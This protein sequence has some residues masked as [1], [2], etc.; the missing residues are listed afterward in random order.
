MDVINLFLKYLKYEKHVSPYTLQAYE[1]DLDQLNTYLQQDHVDLEFTEVTH[2]TLR[3]W[4]V[5]LSTLGLKP[6]SIN[7]K[8][9]A[10]RSFYHFLFTRQ[11]IKQD[12]TLQLKTLKRPQ[13]LPIFFREQELITHLTSHPFPDT[14]EGTRDQLIIELLYGTGIRLGELLSLEEKHMNLYTCTIRVQGKGN[15]ERMV[16][17]PQTILPIINHYINHRNATLS[18][19]Y[20]RLLVTGA[21]KP[22]YPMLVYKR[23]KSC[24]GPYVQADRCSPHVLRHTF[25][26]H[27][28]NGGANL[29]AIKELLGHASLAATQIYTHTSVEKLKEA[30]LKSHPRA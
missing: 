6:R 27:L 25:A 15:K 17:F 5:H 22:C 2:K 4:V 20:P 3:N 24:L 21:N 9:A 7:R 30:F 14:F 16:P 26:T 1:I 12:Y 11:Y 18:P 19:P 8:I 29:P 10:V 28:L 23:L 13:D